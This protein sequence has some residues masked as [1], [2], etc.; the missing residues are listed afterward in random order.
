MSLGSTVDHLLLFHLLLFLVENFSQRPSLDVVENT[1][2]SILTPSP[3]RGLL[4]L[5][6]CIQMEEPCYFPV[7]RLIHGPAAPPLL[8]ATP[9]H[10]Q[11]GVRPLARIQP[12]H[13][14]QRKPIRLE[15]MVHIV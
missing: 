2:R 11:R 1:L 12:Q 10:Q 3:H 6:L 15:N 14:Y 4:E 7:P 8:V 13:P 5:L 9:S